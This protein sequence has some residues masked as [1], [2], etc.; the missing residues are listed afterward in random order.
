MHVAESFVALAR[1]CK[2]GEHVWVG[3]GVIAQPCIV[4]L[5]RRAPGALDLLR[6]GL[7]HRRLQA[8]CQQRGW[9]SAQSCGPS[10]GSNIFG[11]RMD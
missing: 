10:S 5:P 2:V 8:A 11:G 4:V 1:L 3:A 9:A 6:P 7:S